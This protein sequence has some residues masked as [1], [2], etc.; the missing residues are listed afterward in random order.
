MLCLLQSTL[1]VS[2]HEC[3]KQV[4]YVSHSTNPILTHKELQEIVMTCRIH[5][6]QD[7]ITGLLLYKEGGIAQ[8]IEGPENALDVTMERIRNDRRHGGIIVVLSRYVDERSFCNW[9]I[10]FRN[11]EYTVEMN[12]WADEQAILTDAEEQEL[13][14]RIQESAH[15]P[16]HRVSRSIALLINTYQRILLRMGPHTLDNQWDRI[17]RIGSTSSMN[18]MRQ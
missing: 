16:P 3:I 8:L 13:F 5:N 17:N 18:E 4:V 7:D 9:N 15:Q 1:S 10:A 12:R 14:D 6:S 11:L 2:S